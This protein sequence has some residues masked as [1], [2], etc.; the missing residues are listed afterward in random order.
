MVQ[1]QKKKQEFCKALTTNTEQHQDETKEVVD[2]GKQETN[3]CTF[4]KE[5]AKPYIFPLINQS[6]RAHPR[7]GDT[8]SKDVV[9]PII[10]LL[11]GINPT[12][13]IESLLATQI[14]SVHNL[15]MEQLSRAANSTQVEVIEVYANSAAK[16]SRTFIAQ[17]EALD[18]HRGRGGQTGSVGHVHVNNGG[19]AIVGNLEVGGG[20]GNKK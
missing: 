16:L 19:Q 5:T 4:F 18:R 8:E 15:C 12:N 17:L 10:S 1:K 20:S 6:L 11:A 3:A 2:I 7:K 14:I 9:K 13:A